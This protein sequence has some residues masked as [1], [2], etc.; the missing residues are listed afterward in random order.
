MI[1]WQDIQYAG[2]MLV[3]KPGFAV[4]VILILA[5]GIGANTAIFSTLNTVLFKS[6][7]YAEPD[8]LVF[9]RSTFD[10][11]LGPWVS[12]PDYF[13]YRKQA[14]VFESLAMFQI[15]GSYT[16]TGGERPERIPGSIVSDNFFDALGVQPVAGRKFSPEEGRPG[17]QNVVMIS[18]PYA[19][20]RYSAA[21]Q[22]IGQ[23]VN[24]DGQARTVIGVVPA[25]FHFMGEADLWIPTFPGGP[26]TAARRF[27]NWHIVGRLKDGVSLNQAQRQLDV[28]SDRL[29]QEYPGS[30]KNK[31][32][33]LDPLH[34]TLVEAETPRLLLLMG[35]VGLL[36]LIACGNVAGLLLARGST[37][38]MEL[39]LR[40]ALGASRSRIIMQ[41]LTEST[42]LALMG[43]ALG[44]ALAYWLQSL[45]PLIIPLDGLGI[46]DIPLELPALGFALGISLLTGLLFGIVPA[47]RSASDSIFH[48]LGSGTRT[49][50]ARST[51][52]MRNGLVV[53]QVALSVMLLIGA[54]LLV[55]SFVQLTNVDP[56]F[57]ADHLLTGMV[58]LPPGQ[59]TESSQYT[60]FYS[61][62]QVDLTAIP[63]VIDVG[64]IN[65][66]PIRNPYNNVR[67]WAAK[68]PPTESN[69]ARTAYT[70][71]VLPGYFQTME[72]PIIS[73]RAILNSDGEESD[74]VLVI[75]QTMAER[76]FPG[77][78]PV[79][80]RVSVDMGGRG[81][82]NFVVIGVIGDA[83]LQRLGQEPGMAM[84]H[85]FYQFPRSIMRLAI[86][87]RSEPT[88]I[89]GAVQEAVWRQDRD[90]P[91]EGLA[92]MDAIISDS[93]APY[94]ATAGTL[95]LFSTVALLL[96]AIGL[97]G[98]LAYYVS[99]RYHEIGVRIALGA[100]A[101][102]VM[103]LVI[104]KGL[105]LVG[106]GL[107]L[108]AIGSWFGTR[109]IQ[110]MLYDTP[111][112][113]PAVFLTAVLVFSGIGLLACLIPAW[114]AICVDPM[115]TLRQ[116]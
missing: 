89:T 79:G 96:A 40:A 68:R 36:L 115:V 9:G 6:L 80:D 98:V 28:I 55:R 67:A 60:R 52:Y 63:G 26:S 116:D 59:Y 15:R 72:M 33:R 20:R 50:D 16:V 29:K 5:I 58:V 13:D 14:D 18:E 27:H 7:P 87:T 81:E 61:Q 24:M 31:A 17:A 75:N 108:G 84:Y 71:T 73:G 30:N 22:A 37:R 109:L 83:R 53:V 101:S 76:L 103:G 69:R 111:A 3:K 44:V 8:R 104:S 93:V 43:G 45:V 74:P 70:R 1:L 4:V 97:Y 51:S 64:L 105:A 82:V 21:A 11:D 85:S 41:M 88:D 32:L 23:T 19:L 94:R 56:G 47:L 78:D 86:R 66:L 113:D 99:Q 106:I 10:G 65:Q 100:R 35:S 57:R 92:T 12:S 110:D 114:R 49:T 25:G 46:R 77:E 39:A 62:L 48:D 54:G 107:T 2:R 95:G 91:V 38:R 102:H 90:V 112:I 34:E 42:L